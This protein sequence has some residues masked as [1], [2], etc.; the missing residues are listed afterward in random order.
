MMSQLEGI[1][2]RVMPR[3][4]QEKCMC[5]DQY[6]MHLHGLQRVENTKLIINTNPSLV[7]TK[8]SNLKAAPQKPPLHAN[9]NQ[10]HHQA[11]EA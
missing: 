10:P 3:S 1:L 8:I 7:N 6:G 9:H 5:T 4:P 2:G 11:M